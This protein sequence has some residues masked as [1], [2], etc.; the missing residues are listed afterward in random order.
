MTVTPIGQENTFENRNAS[1]NSTVKRRSCQVR[2]DVVELE[3]GDSR[4]V[5]QW[6]IPSQDARLW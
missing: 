1:R 4:R 5:P 3:P 6:F 2:A